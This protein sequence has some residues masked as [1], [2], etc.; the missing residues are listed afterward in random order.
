MYQDVTVNKLLTTA[1]AQNKTLYQSSSN[2]FLHD[3]VEQWPWYK[4]EMHDLMKIL[5][6]THIPTIRTRIYSRTAQT[7]DK[8]RQETNQYDEKEAN[9]ESLI[10]R[11]Y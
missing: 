5:R 7:Q 11:F 8:Q 4:A 2:V 3:C 9:I 1:T 10:Q 6:K